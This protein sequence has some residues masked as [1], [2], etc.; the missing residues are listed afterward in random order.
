MVYIA[1]TCSRTFAHI[2]K[3]KH[4]KNPPVPR[5]ADTACDSFVNAD[6]EC[7]WVGN[8]DFTEFFVNHNAAS[9]IKIGVDQGICETF[10]QGFMD[11]RIIYPQ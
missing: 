11:R 9:A 6:T 2:N 5:I 8:R 4:I 7:A 10:P 1:N 3:G